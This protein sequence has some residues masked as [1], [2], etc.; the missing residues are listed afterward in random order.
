VRDFIVEIDLIDA[1]ILTALQKDNRLT[2]D[3]LSAVVNLSP[4]AVQRRLKRLRGTGVI[5]GDVSIVSPKSVNRPISM[6]VSVTLERERADII[7]RLKRSIRAAPEIM[8]GYY[9]TGESDFVLIIT[10]KSMDDYEEFTRR[11]FYE[12]TDIKNFKTQ[13]IIDRV[14]TGFTLPIEA[15]AADD[16]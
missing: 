5:E 11:F 12:H 2:S 16:V 7:D 13:V 14:K 9:V 3:Q 8:S 1:R 4:T 6:L 10:A 15:T